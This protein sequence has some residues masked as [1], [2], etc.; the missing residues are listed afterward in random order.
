ML[1]DKGMNRL[2]LGFLAVFGI[3]KQEVDPA[4]FGLSQGD[5]GEGRAPITFGAN[6]REAYRQSSTFVILRLSPRQ[7]NGQDGA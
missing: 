1:L 2:D 3:E 6:L 4:S 5:F 7:R